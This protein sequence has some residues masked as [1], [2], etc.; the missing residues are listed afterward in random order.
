VRGAALV[1]ALEGLALIVLGAALIAESLVG[2]PSSVV[3]SLINAVLAIAL[4]AVLILFGRSFL[5][6]RRWARTPAALIQALALPVAWSLAQSQ[7][8]PIAAAVAVPALVVLYLLVTPAARLVFH[9]DGY[10]GS[11]APRS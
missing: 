3:F 11:P 4:G 8:W 2:A 1:L 9:R 7:H 10:A 5:H 6:L